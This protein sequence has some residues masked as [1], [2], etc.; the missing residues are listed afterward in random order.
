MRPSSLAR[1]LPLARR[2]YGFLEHPLETTRPWG[3][4]FL[5]LLAMALLLF[6]LLGGTR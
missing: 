1:W 2:I 4:S 6:L 3:F 5:C